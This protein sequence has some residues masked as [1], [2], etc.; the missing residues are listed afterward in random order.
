MLSSQFMNSGRFA[1]MPESLSPGTREPEAGAIREQV[2]RIAGSELFAASE[3]MR[4][5]LVFAAEQTIA[6]RVAALKEYTI[7]V[8]VFDRPVSFDPGV[9]PIVRVE[10]RRLREKLDLYYRSYGRHDLVVIDVPKGGYA[11]RFRWKGRELPPAVPQNRLT[12]ACFAAVSAS[13][14]TIAGGLQFELVDQFKRVHGLAVMAARPENAEGSEGS[15]LTGSVHVRGERVRI[16]A[17]LLD[18]STRECRWSTALESKLSDRIC[19]EIAESIASL[20]MQFLRNP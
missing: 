12:V 19:E 7:G 15:V 10:A 3:R 16:I 2:Q 13:S 4:R 5:F 11:A 6:G 8:Q 18:T 17:H 9:D 1:P 20:A 14:D